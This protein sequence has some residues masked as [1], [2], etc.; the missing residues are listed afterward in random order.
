MGTTKL[1]K[2][3]R[4]L[5]V[6]G[7]RPCKLF[8]PLGHVAPFTPWYASPRSML[9]AKVCFGRIGPVTAR[10]PVFVQVS[11]ASKS[12]RL[13]CTPPKGVVPA[14]PLGSAAGVTQK[15]LLGSLRKSAPSCLAPESD[16]LPCHK[17]RYSCHP[18]KVLF[19]PELM[20]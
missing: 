6:I 14:A 1:R 3:R 18:R 12:V 15:G 2:L 4:N 5:S 19:F 17:K 11:D 7:L 9:S 10:K 8:P 13:C 16:G 20:I